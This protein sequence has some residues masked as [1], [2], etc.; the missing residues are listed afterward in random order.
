MAE[1][2]FTGLLIAYLDGELPKED[3]VA[4]ERHLPTCAA[5]T[6]AMSAIRSVSVAAREAGPA[7][8]PPGLDARLRAAVAEAAA[9]FHEGAPG[10]PMGWV[11]FGRAAAAAL[12]AASAVFMLVKLGPKSSAPAP[13]R[14]ALVPRYEEL[15]PDP[16][17]LEFAAL[18]CGMDTPAAVCHG[19]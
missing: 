15:A 4:L 18:D 10:L 13:E 8:L 3:C 2:G 16:A 11:V 6:R 17:A 1:D 19:Y 12:V 9:E 7:P 5:C 14:L